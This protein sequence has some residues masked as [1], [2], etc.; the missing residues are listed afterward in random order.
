MDVSTSMSTHRSSGRTV[1][2]HYM[3]SVSQKDI[4]DPNDPRE[5]EDL[6]TAQEKE[7]EDQQTA[8]KKD[9]IQAILGFIEG[10]GYESVFDFC[11]EII[12]NI[13]QS[14]YVKKWMKRDGIAKLFSS[15]V[16]HQEFRCSPALLDPVCHLAEE[17][18]KQEVSML[19][20]GGAFMS[21]L[22]SLSLETIIKF[23]LD[24]LYAT[25]QKELPRTT[26]MLEHITRSD[27]RRKNLSSDGTLVQPESI[28]ELPQRTAKYYEK[29]QI[30]R[31]LLTTVVACILAY[32]RSQKS[33]M[34]QGQIGY[35]LVASKTPK[36]V[37]EVLH[38]LGV[39][40]TYETVLKKFKKI[41]EI[42]AVDLRIWAALMLA[43]FIS[44]DNANFYARVRDQRE[45][46]Q[47]EMINYTVGWVGMNP[48]CRAKRMFTLADINR[49]NIHQLEPEALLPTKRDIKSL[50]RAFEVGIFDCMKKYCGVHMEKARKDG[51]PLESFVIQSIYQIPTQKTQIFTLPTYDKNEAN[52]DEVTEILGCINR[53]LGYTTEQL[54][55]KLIMYKGDFLTVR[56]IR[57]IH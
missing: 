45:N 42:A 16:S 10:H 23:S 40:V 54:R 28:L 31:P 6:E 36:P 55:G 44:F 51:K 41:A 9:N 7:I 52:V 48:L 27:R 20:K 25:I 29:D 21:P 49:S 4:T 57:L 3:N 22:Q 17:T 50:R 39:S 37:I 5:I 53:D 32:T 15:C 14:K 1:R 46:H 56:N 13:D 8:Q 18:Y 34:L 33:N 26:H 24:D 12:R 2:R 30:K 43:F 38:R 19:V 47:A 35:F 11:E